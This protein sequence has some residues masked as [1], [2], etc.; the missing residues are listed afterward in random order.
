MKIWTEY[1]EK[2]LIDNYPSMGFEYC[3][4]HINKSVKQIRT[5]LQRIGL[6]LNPDKKY[7]YEEFKKL[8]NES[9][10]LLDACRNLGLGKNYG[11]RQT[12]KKYIDKYNLDISHFYIPTHNRLK[13]LDL[14]DILVNNSSYRDSTSLKNKL[15]KAG[16]KDRICELCGQGENWQGNHMSLILDHINGINNDNR[17]ENLRIVCP[18]CNATLETHCKGNNKLSNKY[19]KKTKEKY[20]F[21]ECGKKI[22]ITSNSCKRCNQLNQ[23]KTERPPYETL[24][25]ELKESNY[26][27]VGRKYGVSDNSIRKWLDSYKKQLIQYENI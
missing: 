16:L 15:Y 20:K 4:S 3:L 14:N 13:R 18:N 12:V 17:I 11:N 8:I 27:A 19:I 5:K 9:I 2:F 22:L 1:E 24:L 21:C 7:E 26:S 10:N 6:K 25:K 23:R